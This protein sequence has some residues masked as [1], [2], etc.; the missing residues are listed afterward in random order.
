MA[1]VTS[2]AGESFQSFDEAEKA[3]VEFCR[4]EFHPVRVDTK[5]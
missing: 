1:E 4:G 5:G 3:V 2:N